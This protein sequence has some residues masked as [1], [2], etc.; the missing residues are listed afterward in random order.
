[1]QTSTTDRFQVEHIEYVSDRSRLCNKAEFLQPG[2]GEAA[3]C[4]RERPV[5]PWCRGKKR[6]RLTP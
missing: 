2:R 5:I 6:G 4:R 1:M 3:L